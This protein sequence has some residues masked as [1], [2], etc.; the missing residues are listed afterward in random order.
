MVKTSLKILTL[1]GM[2][3]LTW[4]SITSIDSNAV[5]A[6]EQQLQQQNTNSVK[7]AAGGG[8]GT[9]P[10]TIFYPKNIEIKTGQSVT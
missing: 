3:I 1:F 7:V 9:S 4:L 8:N 6:M 10:L 2:M 5:N